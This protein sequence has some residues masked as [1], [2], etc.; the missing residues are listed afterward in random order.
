MLTKVTLS[1]TAATEPDETVE[2][3]S[4]D[5]KVV[6]LNELVEQYL[7]CEQKQQAILEKL[8]TYPVMRA[9]REKGAIRL[10]QVIKK[11]LKALLVPGAAFGQQLQAVLSTWNQ[12][13]ERDSEKQ[14]AI[15]E[16]NRGKPEH[17]R[18]ASV[19]EDGF[20]FSHPTPLYRSVV[21]ENCKRGFDSHDLMLK[22]DSSASTCPECKGKLTPLM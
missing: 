21:C 11:A 4:N 5:Q 14:T 3:I 16:F 18:I 15:D 19:V 7:K 2:P 12:E 9:N 20:T 22:K 6:E 1:R 10:T 17:Q 8:L 13:A